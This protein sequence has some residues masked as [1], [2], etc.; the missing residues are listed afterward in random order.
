MRLFRAL[1]IT[2]LAAALPASSFAQTVADEQKTFDE[3]KGFW[4]KGAAT[5]WKTPVQGNSSH[6]IMYRD[7]PLTVD[8]VKLR[9]QKEAEE[10]V[11]TAQN[12]LDASKA[13]ANA[14]TEN[15]PKTPMTR[16]QIIAKYG[17]PSEPLP[18]RAQKESPPEMQALF[19]A[20]NSG[21]KELAWQY[22]VA[23]AER[24]NR[25]KSVVSK[26]TDYQLLAME[27]TGQR[28]STELNP[29]ADEMGATRL[30]LRDFMEKT[31]MERMQQKF[32]GDQ[33]LAAAGV[34]AEGDNWA[35]GRGAEPHKLAPQIPVDPAGKVKVL[36]FFDERDPNAKNL[37]K[38]LKPLQEKYKADA[39]VSFFGLTMRS[40][41]VP[42][43]KRV[44]EITSFPFPLVNGEAL[45]PELRILRYPT[46]VFLAVTA[47]QTYHLEGQRNA[48]EVEK[49]LNVMKGLKQ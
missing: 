2:A 46:F 27:A 14:I 23:L 31:K 21:D 36:I 38:S 10:A 37:A 1:I 5:D 15:A 25:I 32:Q 40:Y 16:D 8:E 22:S 48:E 39:N 30:E 20:L 11:K 42:G 26:A 49:V 47:K 44:G 6:E 45:A 19:E 24:N 3:Q 29:E 43:L 18:I 28:P 34:T 12:A 4:R 13:G 7:Y 41:A 17:S 35:A 9:I 33:A